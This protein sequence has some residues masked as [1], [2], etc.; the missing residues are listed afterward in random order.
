MGMMFFVNVE[1]GKERSV[2]K[3]LEGMAFDRVSIVAG[4]PYDII[5]R[6]SANLNEALRE[7][8]RHEIS[9]VHGVT[10]VILTPTSPAQ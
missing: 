5:V 10:N 6:H 8:W 1:P 9:V 4:G 3:A 2:K 7:E